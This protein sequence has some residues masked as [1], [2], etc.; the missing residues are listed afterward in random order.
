MELL[1]QKKW[2]IEIRNYLMICVGL[3]IF[4]V[5]WTAFLIPAEMT[6]GGVSGIA[7]IV[8]FATKTIPMGITTFVI[9][10]LLLAIAWRILGTRF[11]INTLF[12]TVVLQKQLIDLKV[13]LT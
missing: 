7:A 11:C 10:A 13:I 6:G 12:C 2:I 4:A 3:A 1:N 8:F 5:G 9:N